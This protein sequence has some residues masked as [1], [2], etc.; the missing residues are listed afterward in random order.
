MFPLIAQANLLWPT[1]AKLAELSQAPYWL[2]L[3]HMRDTTSGSEIVD[4]EFFLATKGSLD[5]KAEL[6][7]TL[8]SF[9]LAT[10]S[11]INTHSQCR[12]PARFNWLKQQLPELLSQTPQIQ[13]PLLS[14]WTDK[15]QISS[16]SAIFASGYLGNPASF[17]GHVLLKFNSSSGAKNILQQQSLNFG[18][19]VPEKENPL[20]YI[21]KGIFGGYDAMFSHGL[22]YLNVQSYGEAEL[23]DLWEYKLDLQPE[24]VKSL[25]LHA[26]ELIGRNYQY[27]FFKQNCAFRMAELL[28]LVV[29]A[30]LINKN[31]PWA[32]PVSIFHNMAMLQQQ[33]NPLVK[34]VVQHPSRQQRFHQA[35]LDLPEPIKELIAVMVQQGFTTELADYQQLPVAQKVKVLQLL[36]DYLEFLRI[37]KHELYSEQAKRKLLKAR[38]ILPAAAE[39]PVYKTAAA[40]HQSTLPS[41]LQLSAI[42]QKQ[43]S[44]LQ[45]RFR[46][47]YHDMLTSDAARVPYSALS[48][49]DLK[50]RWQDGKA[51]LYSFDL[52]NIENMN[53]SVTGLPADGG[54]AWKMN[55]AYKPQDLSCWH[56]QSLQ[57]NAGLGKATQWQASLWYLM[58]DGRLHQDRFETGVTSAEPRVGVVTDITPWWRSQLELGYRY[59]FFGDQQKFVSS[60]W[61]NRFG[62][63]KN[64]D[65]RFSVEKQK[66]T[67]VAL[68]FGYY[69]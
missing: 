7:T 35:Y 34:E 42:S 39:N 12:F 4:P 55:I 49:F 63:Q 41:L 25:N 14:E 64:W 44:A 45:L 15:D 52:L 18:A 6:E 9:F 23:R 8:H 59:Y 56:C 10:E 61:L 16:V 69:W 57:F 53:L 40:P 47:T 22:F 66:E 37:N 60:K 29:D 17:Y 65:L 43:R 32:L 50:L 11:D 67:E 21:T 46:A 48:M 13:C 58:L 26:W 31:Q 30:E 28:E 54:Y 20:V 62:Q 68:S 2:A 1:P 24:Q 5:A 3:L 27:F 36:F 51:D 19:A 38:L 33:G